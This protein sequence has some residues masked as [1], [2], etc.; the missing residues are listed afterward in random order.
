MKKKMLNYLC[1]GLGVSLVIQALCTTISSA[2][3][4]LAH[5]TQVPDCLK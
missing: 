5:E 4:H 1:L 3:A 2:C